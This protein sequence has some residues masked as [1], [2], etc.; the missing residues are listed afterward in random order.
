MN[1]SNQQAIRKI[2]RWLVLVVF[3]VLSLL[4]LNSAFYSAWVS[5]GPPNPYPIGWSRRALG[6]LCFALAALLIGIGLFKG[7]KTLPKFGKSSVAF[8]VIGALLAVAPYI[9]R[10]VLI[11]AC[12]DRGEKWNY[13]AIQC[14]DE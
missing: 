7:I 10:F 14:S 6:H 12:L 5:G 13:E 4:Y 1:N 11:D 2:I 8:V 3:V 9:G